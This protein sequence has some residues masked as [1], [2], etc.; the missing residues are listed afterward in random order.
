ML[1]CGHVYF[2]LWITRDGRSYFER[3][4]KDIKYGK[5]AIEQRAIIKISATTF[6]NR[7]NLTICCPSLFMQI[8][9][10]SLLL[11]CCFINDC[12]RIRAKQ[13]REE[14]LPVKRSTQQKGNH[15][16]NI[17]INYGVFFPSEE[18]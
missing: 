5:T 8:Y 16:N 18:F 12:A 1:I 2:G 17:K 14:S 3:I 6:P 11:C 13:Y 15:K 4:P 7:F 9:N 10:L